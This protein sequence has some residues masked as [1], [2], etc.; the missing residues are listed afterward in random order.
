MYYMKC[1]L[2]CLKDIL[3]KIRAISS[4][5][6]DDSIWDQPLRYFWRGVVYITDIYVQ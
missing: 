6:S 1:L 5:V 3:K 2:D 4:I